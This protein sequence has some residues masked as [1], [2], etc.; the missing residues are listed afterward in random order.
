M[1]DTP[2]DPDEAVRAFLEYSQTA[3]IEEYASRGRRYR[4][5]AAE[6]LA[7]RWC[8][9]MGQW[10]IDIT[11]PRA[12]ADI[13]DVKAE[14][15]AR[16]EEPPWDLTKAEQRRIA[17]AMREWLEEI[18]RHDSE[19]WAE[20]KKELHVDIAAFLKREAN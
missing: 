10:A 3:D 9:A 18:K 17:D 5:L 2:C 11:N 6:A 7:A 14:Y 12:R 8:I 15:A 20:M 19:R 4:G 16:G 13:S 1:S